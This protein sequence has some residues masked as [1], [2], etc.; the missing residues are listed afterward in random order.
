LAAE[1][2]KV[3]EKTASILKKSHSKDRGS[4]L[5]WNNT[6]LPATKL[7][8]V[9]SHVMEILSVTGVRIETTRHFFCHLS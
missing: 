5:V 6:K 8:D 2:S 7:Y 9:T 4:L 3:T 1:A